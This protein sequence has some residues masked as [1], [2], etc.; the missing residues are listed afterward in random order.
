V[1]EAGGIEKEVWVDCYSDPLGWD[2]DVTAAKRQPTG[3]TW[4]TIA[5]DAGMYPQRALLNIGRSCVRK[6]LTC[7]SSQMASSPRL[8]RPRKMVCARALCRSF[9]RM[10]DTHLMPNSPDVAIGHWAD[11]GREPS[12]AGGR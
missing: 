8:D 11:S 7:N 5:G 10:H 12:V 6:S 4:Y 2:G 3:S 9:H 1:E